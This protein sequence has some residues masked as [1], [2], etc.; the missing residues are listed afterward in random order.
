MRRAL[1]I[2]TALGRA[3]VLLVIAAC[4]LV[5]QVPAATDQ[6]A[7]V[8][9]RMRADLSAKRYAAV[10]TEANRLLESAR[11]ISTPQRVE[12]WQL[13][14]A[15]YY[16]DAPR[17]QMPD[18]ARLPLVALIRLAPD[19]KIPREF[20]WA[21]LD[22]LTELTRAGSFA[23]VTRPLSE[24]TLSAQ[25]GASGTLDVVA[26]RPT[27][28]FLTSVEDA[29]GRT[30]V[31]DSSDFVTHAAL[32]LRTHDTRGPVFTDGRYQLH[33][34]AYDLA[35]GDSV[36]IAHRVRAVRSDLPPPVQGSGVPAVPVVLLPNATRPAARHAAAPHRTAMLWG[37]LALAAAT[38]AVAQEARPDDGIR[39]AFTV[40]ARAFIV[41]AVM[42]G[43]A[44]TNFFAA[45]GPQRGARR[46]TVTLSAPRLPPTSFYRVRLLIDPPER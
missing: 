27:R 19:I 22:Q 34:W 13:L 3:G 46:P 6:T 29:S 21:G 45:R 5:A 37:G 8:L 28:F 25:E 15:A 1:H 23:V 10:I 31:H 14:A 24:Y 18:S 26:S 4:A 40:D 9:A 39:S 41:G 43:A 42:A 17:G 35:S 12:L 30:V 44:V 11:V 20:S 2:A 36:R 38:A 16:P 7:G 32:H 33:V